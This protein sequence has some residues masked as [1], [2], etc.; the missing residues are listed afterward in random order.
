MLVFLFWKRTSVSRI[1]TLDRM[2]GRQPQRLVHRQAQ[3]AV[4]RESRCCFAIPQAPVERLAGSRAGERDA[5]L[6]TN[7]QP[8]LE[9]A[10]Q[11]APR[12]ATKPLRL[13]MTE[14]DLAIGCGHADADRLIV[15]KRDIQIEMRISEPSAD[16]FRRLSANPVVDQLWIVAMIERATDAD[17]AFE[18]PADDAGV[19]DCGGTDVDGCFHGAVSLNPLSQRLADN[20]VAADG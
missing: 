8:T 19:G 2:S 18:N 3:N 10:H 9:I 4:M 1:Y 14:G 7:P 13:H 17:R 20:N 15:K 12:T 11:C 6:A 5:R 16:V